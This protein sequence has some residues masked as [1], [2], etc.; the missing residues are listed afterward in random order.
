MY[1][2]VFDSYDNDCDFDMSEGAEDYGDDGYEPDVD[3]LQEHQDFAQDDDYVNEDR[4]LE[5]RYEE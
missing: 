1:D 5:G 3:E 2:D 4:F